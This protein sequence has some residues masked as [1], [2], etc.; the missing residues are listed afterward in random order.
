MLSLKALFL[1]SFCWLLA[2]LSFPWFVAA[3]LQSL[4]LLS[5][6]LLPFGCVCVSPNLSLLIRTTVTGVRGH[7]IQYDLRRKWK[8]L[9]CVRLFAT[10]WTIQSMN[11][12]GQNAG[13]GSL[14]LIQ[15]IFLTQELNQGLLHCRRILYQLSCEGSPL[16]I[17]EDHISK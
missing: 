13:M 2:I 14:S 17:C 7:L 16:N 11:S 8:S 4:P 15:G 12:P 1:S 10:P 5:Q 6:G 9:S 3:S